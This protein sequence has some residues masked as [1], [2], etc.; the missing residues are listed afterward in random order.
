MWG[1]GKHSLFGWHF[2]GGAKDQTGTF[3]KMLFFENFSDSR[4]CK[5]FSKPKFSLPFFRT[6]N[7]GALNIWAMAMN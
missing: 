1:G 2:S 7:R 6:V 3:E 5:T 4:P